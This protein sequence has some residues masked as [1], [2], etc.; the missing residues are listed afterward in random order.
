MIQKI[1]LPLNPDDPALPLDPE[2]PLA[3]KLPVL[4]NLITQASKLAGPDP[5]EVTLSFHNQLQLLHY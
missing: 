4:K 1:H 3:P 5:Q 2:D